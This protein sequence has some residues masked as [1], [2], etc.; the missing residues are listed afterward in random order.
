M[1][2][3]ICISCLAL[4]LIV[5][6]V[7]AEDNTLYTT[8][9]DG[10]S[11]PAKR[12]GRTTRA[13]FKEFSLTNKTDVIYKGKSLKRYPKYHPSRYRIIKFQFD[14]EKNLTKVVIRRAK[15]HVLGETEFYLLPKE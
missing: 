10:W 8:R 4:L 15:R 1:K 14:E 13:L 9:S 3:L 6:S 2:K 5:F 12:N 11:Y 7:S